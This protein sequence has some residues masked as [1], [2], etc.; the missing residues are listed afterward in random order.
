[1]TTH[2]VLGIPS[3][4]RPLQH[5][6]NSGARALSLSAL[7]SL[8]L[9]TFTGQ[10]QADTDAP[11]TGELKQLSVEQLMSIQVTSVARHPEKL[12]RAA[13]AIQVITQEEIRRSGASSIPEALRLADNLEVAQ[14]NSHDWAITARGFNTAL[15]NKLLVM[16]DGRTVYTPLYSG[17][18]WDV[19]DYLLEDIDR[20]EVISGPGGTL[21]GANAVN[22]V[23]N[24]ITRSAADS[25]GLYAEAGGGSQLE[26]FGGARYGGALA[27]GVNFRVYGKY[28]N[29]DDE[30]FENGSPA[31]DGWHH[32]QGGFRI[33]SQ[34]SPQNTLS[35]HGDFYAGHEGMNTGGAIENSGG[36]IVGHWTHVFSD[37]S[38][39]SLQ[40]YYDR[41]HLLDPVPMFL[42]G[43]TPLVPAGNLRDDLTTYDI[44][45]Q[46]RFALGG[47]NRVVWGLGYRF[48]HDVVENAP[49]LGFSPDVLNQDLFS[50]FL[51]DE[52][53]LGSDWSVTLGS[54]LE[55][56]DYTGFEVE[57]N[58]RVEWSLAPH[59]ALWS[60]I[61]RAART[62][63]RID[64]DFSEP[65]R[66]FPLVILAGSGTF[67]SEY[68]T[69]YELGYRG[70]VA[71]DFTGSISA[72]YNVYHDV[73]STSSTPNTILPL[74]FANNVE[75][76]T[77]GLELSGNYQVF[78]GWSLH[79]GYDLLKENLRVQPG[80]FDFSNARNETADP[81]QQVSL[82]SSMNLPARVEL[83]TTLR[84]VDLLKT[85]NGPA[86]GTVPSYLEMDTR[87]AWHAAK[88]LELSV[89]GQNLLH[90]HH[91]EYGFPGPTRVAIE[92]NVYG[93]IAWQY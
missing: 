51:Q 49:G 70:E 83:D 91:A 50:A 72:F 37:R 25:Q 66:P 17:V 89:V 8:V 29:R 26:E 68:V 4:R 39:M 59:Q 7:A 44:D 87:L 6:R 47:R 61:S 73:R 28:L 5:W 60:A 3:R 38:D 45:F 14:K 13:A 34:S 79:A 84:W 86:L 85:N 53:L 56:N 80:Q 42:L 78:D 81:Q 55:H 54:K 52:I 92:R 90:D 9:S 23:I 48:T 24:I 15:G 19:Q 32:A 20:I 22:G 21:W 58:A 57:P 69:A 46:H 11:S 43:T 77:Y 64:R 30:V 35:L 76:D 27:P 75:G 74:F 65:A 62:P 18:F 16:I 63:S 1:M 36:N 67:G 71:S 2:A 41:T 10:T 88:G 40:T 12:L 82:R 33:D 93:K 31:T